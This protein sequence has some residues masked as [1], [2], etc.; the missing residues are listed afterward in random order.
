MRP[1]FSKGLRR[2]LAGESST[3]TTPT[4]ESRA[5]TQKSGMAGQGFTIGLENRNDIA[6]VDL[7]KIIVAE[8][9]MV[10][11]AMFTHSTRLNRSGVCILRRVPDCL[12]SAISR[13]ER[14]H[15]RVGIST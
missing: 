7:G 10:S 14:R 5:A 15:R 6:C 2:S 4:V 11:Q 3:T 1:T 12:M 9:G 8:V 13:E